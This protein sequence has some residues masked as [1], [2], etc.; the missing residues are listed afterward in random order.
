MQVCR[1]VAEEAPSPL[2]REERT[3]PPSI[4]R[5][6][7]PSRPT[8]FTRN[9]TRAYRTGP[10]RPEL[11]CHPSAS[12]LPASSL[13][14][15]LN[16]APSVRVRFTACHARDGGDGPHAAPAVLAV[17]LSLRLAA[18]PRR[19]PNQAGLRFSVLQCKAGRWFAVGNGQT[20][21]GMDI[22]HAILLLPCD[23]TGSCHRVLLKTG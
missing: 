3:P 10:A 7:P 16:F 9:G 17:G 5:N 4:P 23:K 19:D 22:T 11:W 1:R 13:A 6:L 2:A 20:G 8:P 21:A 14:P 15:A 12:S 18:P